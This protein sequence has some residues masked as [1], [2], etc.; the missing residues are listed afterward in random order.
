MR[1]G[2]LQTQL[3]HCTEWAA[4]RDQIRVKLEEAQ[5]NTWFYQQLV[6]AFGKDGI[7]ALIIE[8]AIPEIE[9]ETNAILS[10]LT[11][12]RI[13]ISIESLRDL[14]KGGTRETLDIKIADIILCKNIQECSVRC[15]R[16]FRNGM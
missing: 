3:D 1:Q 13:Q 10:R 7:Q 5:K 8:N 11:D 12:N 2:A 16:G 15:S 9:D 14:K 4:E 6:E